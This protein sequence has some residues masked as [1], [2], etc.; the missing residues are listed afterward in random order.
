MPPT[1]ADRVD[2]GVGMGQDCAVRLRSNWRPAPEDD[3][4]LAQR[5]RFHLSYRLAGRAIQ[6]VLSADGEDRARNT[7]AVLAWAATD[8]VG[9]AALRRSPRF[10]LV[11]RAVFDMVDI[12]QWGSSGED[13]DLAVISGIPLAVESGIRLGPAALVVP[14]VTAT[15]VGVV[16]RHRK[17]PASIG[18]FRWQVLGVGIGTGLAAYGRNRRK[19]VLAR[20]AQELD[21]RLQEAYVGGQNDV[22]MGADSVVDLL[23]RTTPLLPSDSDQHVVGRL[24]ASWKQS[25]A[26]D[27]STR[28]TYLGVAL[29][30]W[31]RQRNTSHH[32]L[33]ADVAFVMDPGA[34]TVLLSASQTFWLGDALDAKPLRGRIHDELI[35][36]YEAAQ[37][38]T[39]RRLRVAGRDLSV[40]AD[41][42]KALTP[43]DVGPSGFV[44]GAMW[45]LDT[46]SAANSKSS[47][48][49]VGPV[50]AG[51]LGL[52]AWSHW[53]VDRH[54]AAAHPRIVAAGVATALAQAVA[55]TATMTRTR[56]SNGMQRY[57]FLSGIDMLGLLVSLYA[58][59]LTP[60]QLVA[61][62]VGLAAVI[63]I[64]IALMPEPIVWS[65]LIG[66]LLW[67]AAAAVSLSGLGSG[68][69]EDAE[70]LGLQLA[71]V[72]STSIDRA[73][74]EG[75]SSVV[76]M[77]AEAGSAA[78][79]AF[80]AAR[81]SI[82]PGVADEIDRRLDEMN[83]RLNELGGSSGRSVGPTLLSP[84]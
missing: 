54:G 47:P 11:P 3:T 81:G 6:F 48:A 80:E 53:Q 5:A 8:L 30:R 42:A 52:A 31:Q 83:R 55:G 84:A 59:D 16:R 35:D 44:I 78:R 67:S 21:A 61:V 49:V 62:G 15:V 58:D 26:A 13:C 32:A 17:L 33:D 72:E 22:A 40:P 7:R 19:V 2:T 43:I 18:S 79:R 71:E 24:L 66:E 63:G 12:V 36:P 20:H 29:A 4:F 45:M 82:V 39:C 60:S 65:H 73:F 56:A 25:L 51:G 68:L 69:N 37:P 28:S 23:S 77:V 50:A 70:Q 34:G 14:M 75:R 27:T 76:A 41:R 10:G 74:A 38:T 1:A 46:L 9:A 57:P 64:G